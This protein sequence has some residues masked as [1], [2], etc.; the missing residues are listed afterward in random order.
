[1][2]L[3]KAI[4]NWQLGQYQTAVQSW[5]EAY[6]LIQA[7][8]RQVLD[9]GITASTLFP[10]A[11]QPEELESYWFDWLIAGLLMRECDELFAQS[12]H[13]LGFGSKP[14]D[15]ADDPALVR[16]L[17]EWQA[18]RGEW[19]QA[20]RRFDDLLRFH[21]A[22]REGLSID[23]L[24][25]AIASLKL[26]DQSS[27]LRLRETVLRELEGANNE[28]GSQNVMKMALLL[29]TDDASPSEL[30][31]FAEVLE[32]AAASAGPIKEGTTTP[33]GWNLMLLGLFEY[34]RGNYAKAIDW[35]RH[36]LGTSTYI[37]MPT[38][39][40]RAILAMSFHKLG[41]DSAARLEFERATGL[42]EGGLNLG[43]DTWHW[44][45]WVI[46]RL[47]LQEA[48]ALIPQAA[49]PAPEIKR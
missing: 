45:D 38:V 46:A 36:S 17:G 31:P 42:V 4:S 34:R 9:L 28:A 12:D 18:M 49:V 35:C 3:I 32:R 24:D 25:D 15:V 37:A 21:E 39:T 2:D 30:Q 7:K 11:I 13:A 22:N 16:S 5:S 23:Y 1:V 27:F 6:E 44:R 19:E 43:I 40:D 14:K 48:E 47:L 10:G 29:P 8:S 41:D 20:R 33:A 26:G